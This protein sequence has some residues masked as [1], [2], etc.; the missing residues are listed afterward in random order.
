[1]N[2]GY[3]TVLVLASGLLGQFNNYPDPRDPT[4]PTDI[5]FEA[6]TVEQDALIDEAIGTVKLPESAIESCDLLITDETLP[7]K[8][9]WWAVHKKMEHLERT[10]RE[11]E[12]IE[13]GRNWLA[14][15]GNSFD[16][17]SLR[18]RL[19][20]V[21]MMHRDSENFVPVYKDVKD[22]YDDLFN[23]HKMDD[24]F[25]VEEHVSYAQKLEALTCINPE[26]HYEAIDQR[27]KALK[28]LKNVINNTIMN[29]NKQ[30]EQTQE[31]LKNECAVY[32]K[33]RTTVLSGFCS[34]TM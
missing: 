22:A 5:P 30:D 33:I 13:T 21:S 29:M 3:I 2:I 7:M 1:M 16:E 6:T 23:N 24:A 18:I 17:E 26:L 14:E 4:L 9:R 11:R 15:Y 12:A 25:W 34:S 20:I 31:Y 8:L 19:Q 27:C 10:E 28:A 32:P